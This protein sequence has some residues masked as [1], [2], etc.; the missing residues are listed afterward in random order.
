MTPSTDQPVPEPVAPSPRSP[1]EDWATISQ[2]CLNHK[3]A[4][5]T[6]ETSPAMLTDMETQLVDLRRVLN[7]VRNPATEEE[8]LSFLVQNTAAIRART[9]NLVSSLDDLTT[10][11]ATLT[12]DQ[13]T[14]NAEVVAAVQA[15]TDA[16]SQKAALQAIIDG[17]NAGDAVTAQNLADLN[18]AAAAIDAGINASAAAL[19][20]VI[21]APTA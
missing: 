13:A 14:E 5:R 1:L 19:A 21:P 8:Q 11:I 4:G 10:T 7:A 6:P 2:L 17:L 20:P 18:T 9:D 3:H 12:S 16:A 15:L